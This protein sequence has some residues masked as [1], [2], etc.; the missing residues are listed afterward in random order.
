[1][2]NAR[3]A[4]ALVAACLPVSAVAQA[5]GPDVIVGDLIDTSNYGSAT[6]IGGALTSAFAIGTTSCNLGTAELN[7]F[8]N[9]N[10]KPVIGQNIY[11]LYDGRIEQIG[12]GWLKHGFYALAQN[13]CA[14][15]VTPS[16]NNGTHLGVNCSDP[17]SA[18]LNGTQSNIGPRFEVNA[19]TGFYPW[20]YSL[21]PVEAN[22]PATAANEGLLAGRIRVLHSDLDAALNPGALYFAEGHYVTPDDAAAGNGKNNVSYRPLNVTFTGSAYSISLI[23]ST[24]RQKPAIWA[25]KA[26]DPS[27][28]ML[29]VD[30][31]AEGRFVMGYRAKSIGGGQ[32]RHEYAVFN[33]N[34]D[35]AGGSFS[36]ALPAGVGATNLSFRDVKYH[37]GEPIIDV[38][39]APTVNTGVSVSWAC[40]TAPGTPS[41]NNAANPLRWGT[42]FNFGFESSAAWL[43]DATLGLWKAG[44]PAS[45][46]AQFCPTTGLPT[47]AVP[48]A[49]AFQSV[50]YDFLDATGG[51]A[52][53][54]GDEAGATVNLPF[55]FSF[56]GTPLTQILIS[57]NGYLAVPGQPHNIYDNV[58]IPNGAQPN[59]V[60]AGY[61][62]DLEVAGPGGSASGWCR[63]QTFG[64]APNR[65]FVVEWFNAQRYQQNNNFSFEIILDEGTNAITLTQISTAT[66]AIG[67]SATRGVENLDGSSGTQLSHNSTTV[68]A[69]T[70]YRFTYTPGSVPQSALLELS[71][72]G[73]FGDPFQWRIVSE[74]SK[75]VTLF[76]D[77]TPGPVSIPGFGEV[78]LS[79]GPTMLAIYDGS[80]AFGPLDPTATTD[81][82]NVWTAALG[83][84]P[85]PLPTPLGLL[86]Q[87]LVWSPT[88]P[89]GLA[90][91]T[92]LATY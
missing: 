46:A 76:V 4:A 32:Y 35:R 57:T 56:Y 82:C 30:V 16:P 58:S 18:S 2:K 69:G 11:R 29:E 47:Q 19:F 42:L 20:P 21:T 14:T 86:F 51:V 1:V 65:R 28:S 73:S 63:Y 36:I 50:P 5:V 34:S 75:L 70:S 38:D 22:N 71:G 6:P 55:P 87:G 7:W 41:Q 67:G 84:V 79:L 26:A 61:W 31:P 74:P 78:A 66:G 60:I 3:F 59:G 49:Y 53:P 62:D 40:T 10:Q 77:V 12:I 54:V 24:Q 72:A 43:P 80:G 92:T 45:V 17:Y 15:C 23:G 52:G 90:H 48:G 44:T 81:A 25:W 37:S 91:I 64:A 9:T 85:D 8:S 68:T 27:V 13:A 89:N 88:A 33:V 83:V 39:W